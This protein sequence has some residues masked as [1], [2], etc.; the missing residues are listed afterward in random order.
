MNKQELQFLFYGHAGYY[1]RGCE[2]I[3][4]STADMVREFFP[5]AHTT[6]ATNHFHS[7]PTLYTDIVDKYIPQR[8]RGCSYENIISKVYLKTRRKN[9]AL[10]WG[11]T[12]LK[13]IVNEGDVFFSIGGDKYCYSK[14]NKLYKCDEII[15]KAGKLNVLWGASI[16]PAL[17]TDQMLEDLKGFDLITS[18][19]SLTYQA[20]SDR[21]LR[22]IY[23]IQILLL[24]YAGKTYLYLSILYRRKPLGLTLARCR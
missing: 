18:R 2:A 19:E 4:R 10:E 22:N 16:D 9:D 8:N 21:G 6:L 15:R 12:W 20:L 13:K 5:G 11:A 7:D 24:R 17:I 1:N 14:P 23:Y 3:V